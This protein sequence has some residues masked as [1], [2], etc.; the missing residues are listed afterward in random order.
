[1]PMRLLTA[2]LIAPLFVA[3]GAGGLWLILRPRRGMLT[4]AWFV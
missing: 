4:G 2:A 3:I 1:M